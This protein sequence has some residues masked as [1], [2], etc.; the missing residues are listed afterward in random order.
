MS[1]ALFRRWFDS[2]A[3]GSL[4]VLGLASGAAQAGPLCTTLAPGVPLASFD[5]C[6]ASGQDTLPAVQAALDLALE[7]NV[8]L[9]GA[10]SFSP[11]PGSAGEEFVGDDPA[12]NFDI[13]P[14]SVAAATNSI[15]FNSLPAGTVF[16]SL[17][18]ANDF[19]IFNVLGLLTPFTLTHQI[20]PSSSTSHISTFAIVPEPSPLLL[21]A[22]GLVGFG[23]M[24][25]LRHQR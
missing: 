10:G 11:G 18:Q 21:L 17:K 19:E 25:L 22:I 23:L 5:S 7:P 15:T 14:D 3:L 20:L 9:S 2:V 12:N 6:V 1:N 13:T 4:L 8:M 16:V 24:N